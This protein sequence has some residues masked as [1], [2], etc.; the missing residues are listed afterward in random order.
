VGWLYLIRHGQAGT[1]DD[2]DRLSALGREQAQ[3]LGA[4]LCVQHIHFE[5]VICG[6]LRRQQETATCALGESVW[7]EDTRWSEFDLD[8][9]YAGIAPQ[10]A[11]ED[12]VFATHYVQLRQAI[13]GADPGI[14][15][16]WAPA[17]VAAI[18]AWVDGRFTYDGESWKQFATRVEEAF[19]EAVSAAQGERRVAVFTSATPV[20]LA[21]GRV[22][23][24]ARPEVLDLAGAGLNANVTILKVLKGVPKLFQFNTI[25]HLDEPR[26][27][28]AR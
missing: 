18:Q 17:D 10:L 3:R 25:N 11:A 28:T 20:A 6:G 23:K 9:V 1:R 21:V 24:L 16:R 7:R 15:R 14:H 19:S 5:E 4:W 13:E 27:W 26:L 22:L 12:P 2:Y 8:A